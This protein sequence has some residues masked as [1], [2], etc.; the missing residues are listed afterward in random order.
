[1]L[2]PR[3]VIQPSSNRHTIF[4][5]Q[6]KRHPYHHRYIGNIMIAMMVKAMSIKADVCVNQTGIYY[7]TKNN[8]HLSHKCYK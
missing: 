4:T 8:S 6:R 1:M 7:A 3:I 2:K 5:G